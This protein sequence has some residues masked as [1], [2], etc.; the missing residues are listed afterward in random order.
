M[1][2]TGTMHGPLTREDERANRIYYII[3]SIDVRRDAEHI[4]NWLDPR[5]VPRSNRD[6]SPED[7]GSQH[8]LWVQTEGDEQW[9]YDYL[10]D[11]MAGGACTGC[12]GN[13]EGEEEHVATIEED[14]LFYGVGVTTTG[15][16][17]QQTYVYESRPCRFCGGTGDRGAAYRSGFHRKW[18]AELN[19]EQFLTLANDRSWDLDEDERPTRYEE[20]MGSLTE[21]GHL[22]AY[23]VH[24]HE[25][26]SYGGEIIDAQFYISEG[27]L[28]YGAR[29]ELG[30]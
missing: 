7:P 14:E 26:W 17:G 22:G 13:G 8:D 6:S 1:A 19:H 15:Y 10:A 25:G 4:V 21:Y 5:H 24:D 2:D 28:P 29:S 27:C 9:D 30:G 18:V 11:E 16:A 3:Y 23:C 12:G 20:T